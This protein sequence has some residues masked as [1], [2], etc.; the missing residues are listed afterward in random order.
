MVISGA[1]TVPKSQFKP[2][3]RI[4]IATPAYGGVYCSEYVKTLYRLLSTKGATSYSFSEVDYSDIVLSRNYLIS[5]FYFNQ[6]KC[7]HILFMD[8]D[9]GF[10]TELIQQMVEL[11]E[12]V[13]GVVAPARTI[14]L[15]KL[16]QLGHLPYEQAYQQSLKFIGKS[17]QPHPK[18]PRFGKVTSI[19]TGLLLISRAAI[20]TMI[21]QIPEV[22]DNQRFKKYPFANRFS[23]FITP[24]DKVR[25][26]DRELSEDF[27]FCHRWTNH[28][29][30]QIYAGTDFEIEHV[31]KLTLKGRVDAK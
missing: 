2:R 29:E 19:G 8:S 25:L 26:E 14:D 13:V 15:E 6:P 28:C 1:V 17:H 24:F 30:G 16:H 20:D 18:N 3:V 7:S 5:N 11:N 23:Q 22:V 10:P 21:T 27:S 9:M 31:S 4:N 12:P